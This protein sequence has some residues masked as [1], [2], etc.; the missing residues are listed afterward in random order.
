ML[1]ALVVGLVVLAIVL[2]MVG[3]DWAPTRGRRR[4]VILEDSPVVVRRGVRY[5][6][7]APAVVEPAA[8]IEERRY[9]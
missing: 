3:S 8:Y 9:P 4:T 5:V 6:E 7:Q 2:L 1:I